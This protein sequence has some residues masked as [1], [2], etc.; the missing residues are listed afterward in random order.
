MKLNKI[1]MMFAL[2]GTFMFAACG[3]GKLDDNANQELSKFEGDWMAATEGLKALPD[4]IKETLDVT[5]ASCDSVCNGSEC[6]K[7]AKEKCDSLKG[8]CQNIHTEMEAMLKAAQEKVAS[9]EADGKAFADWKAKATKGEVKAEDFKKQMEDWNLKLSD[10]NA[11]ATEWS[12]KLADLK[13]Q[14][15]TNCADMKSCCETK[16]EK[17]K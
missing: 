13:K 7:D 16:K 1:L 10:I 9:L 17:K 11:S 3:G 12:T 5:K 14:C 4:Q 8:S 6:K 15:E 2:A